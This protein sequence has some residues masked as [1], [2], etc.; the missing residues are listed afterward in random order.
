MKVDSECLQPLLGQHKEICISFQAFCSED[1]M[2]E[3][4]RWFEAAGTVAVVCFSCL[5]AE[6]FKFHLF[7]CL[8]HCISSL[9]ILIYIMSARRTMA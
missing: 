3:T 4:K 5:C 6:C 2:V 7:L 9:I 1:G 8:I